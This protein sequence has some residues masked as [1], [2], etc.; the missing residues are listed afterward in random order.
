M[1][2]VIEKAIELRKQGKYQESR[3]LLGELLTQKAFEAKA[4]LNIAWS[5]D[6]EGKEKEAIGHYLASL[7]G[8]LSKTE[9]FDA[10]FGLACTYR[11]LGSYENALNYF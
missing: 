9:R 10:L 4:H 2:T 8:V 6:N 1:D 7:E 5:Y 3:T 11:S